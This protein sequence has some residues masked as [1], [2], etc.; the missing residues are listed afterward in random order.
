MPMLRQMGVTAGTVANSESPD[1]D[2]LYATPEDLF[3]LYGLT[4]TEA[5]VRFAQGLINSVCCRTSL[6]PELYEERLTVPSDR[7][8]VV[9]SVTPVVQILT[10]QGRYAYGRRDRRALNMHQMDYIA[11]LAVFGSPPR[12]TDITVDQIEYFPA[13]GEVWLPTGFFLVPWSDVML[14]YLAGFPVIPDRI[15]MAVAE[16]IN[17]VCARG[18]SDRIQ[19]SIG[20]ISRRYA[21]ESYITPQALQLLEPFIVKSLM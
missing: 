20:R 15:K 6:W 21:S 12:Y 18:V 5:Q 11:A 2:K 13:T 19:Y 17:S 9:L 16:L 1:R 14:T 8:Q 3:A 4:V 7:L 10:A